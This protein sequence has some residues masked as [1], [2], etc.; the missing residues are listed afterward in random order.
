MNSKTQTPQSVWNQTSF[1]IVEGD[2]EFRN[3]SEAV[4]RKVG[5]VAVYVAPSGKDGL[6]LQ[7][8]IHA[9]VVLIDFQLSDLH[10]IDFMR[11]IRKL[12]QEGSAETLI[13]PTA[14]S[15][16]AEVLR[17]ACL[18]GIQSFIRKPTDTD[19]FLKRVGGALNNPK[20]FVFGRRFFGPERRMAQVQ[21]GGGNRRRSTPKPATTPRSAPAAG[22][23]DGNTAAGVRDPN[24]A[25]G[26]GD[27]DTAAGVG[28]GNT[29]AGVEDGNTAAGVRDPNTAAGVGDDQVRRP[30]GG[31]EG[32]RRRG[33]DRAASF[34]A[35]G[36]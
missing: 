32:H 5:A 26:V 22:S 19:N 3:W 12:Q 29:A 20:R 36:G 24:A 31:A 34:S 6:T 27:G 11:R 25:S 21:Y 17:Q 2:E 28:D 8:Q 30:G 35:T 9:D 18:V 13:I 16:N 7:E 10:P 14:E 33:A 15:A 1:L 4:L 23:R